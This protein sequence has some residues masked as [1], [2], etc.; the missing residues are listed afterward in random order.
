MRYAY[1]ATA[2]TMRPAPV[3]RRS[4]W[5]RL[6]DRRRKRRRAITA[7]QGRQMLAFAATGDTGTERL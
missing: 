2:G 6:L 3:P 7:A 4:W 1:D 5:V